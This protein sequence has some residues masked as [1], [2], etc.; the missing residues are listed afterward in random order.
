MSASQ[1]KPRVSFTD[2][3]K[4]SLREA[5]AADPYPTQ[6]TLDQLARGLGVGT[7]TVVNWFHNHRMRAKHHPGPATET[8]S[9][10]PEE[11]DPLGSCGE[12]IAVCA[13]SR[14]ASAPDDEYSNESD[15][16]DDDAASTTTT[17]EREFCKSSESEGVGVEE[18]G[19][20]HDDHQPFAVRRFLSY[21]YGRTRNN[22]PSNFDE[23]PDASTVDATRAASDNSE[24]NTPLPPSRAPNDG[25]EEAQRPPR[26]EDSSDT[27]APPAAV[28]VMPSREKERQFVVNR[29]K[30]ARPQWVFEGTVL[31]RSNYGQ[32]GSNGCG[33]F[34]LPVDSRL[35]RRELG[36]QKAES[37]VNING[38]VSFSETVREIST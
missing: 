5:F 25:P 32:L 2:E 37:C 24:R 20:V 4:K 29:R 22:L 26:A 36:H 31:D 33:S 23:N 34:R 19:V 18:L 13:S 35:P 8:T 11:G 38:E 9:H 28:V 12:N 27:A 6:S 14:A 30:S 16:D 7:K 15:D 21:E 17:S 10:G 1:K 3:Q